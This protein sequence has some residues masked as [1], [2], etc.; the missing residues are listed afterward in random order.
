[1]FGRVSRRSS[2]LILASVALTVISCSGPTDLPPDELEPAR[3][4]ISANVSATTITTMVVTVTG[5]GIAV[6][7]VFNLPIDAQGVASGSIGIPAGA[8]RRI[9]LDAF[10]VTGIKTH[11]GERVIGEIRP[12]DNPGVAIVL[13]PLAGNQPVT[14]SLGTFTVTV[15][16]NPM[17]VTI[18]ATNAMT[19]TA[20]VRDKDNVIV[21]VAA[22]DLR[23]A[24]T[25]PAL[26][27]AAR[28]ST[29]ADKG[30]VTGIRAGSGEVIATFNG[31]A[32]AAVVTVTP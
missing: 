26:F 8:N 31:F 32:G 28:H 11:H 7:L 12:G 16:P 22:G 4:A 24:S 20:V 10:D 30:V 17:V 1:M 27:S 14:A 5:P 3:L 29:D 15:T 19:L 23:W 13:L 6:P 18:G 9:D 21:P 25:N 2:S